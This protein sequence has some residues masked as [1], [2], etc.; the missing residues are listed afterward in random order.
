MP[1]VPEIEETLTI[2]R[3]TSTPSSRSRLAGSRMCGAAARMIRNG[4]I[5]W[6]SSILWNAS[7][8]IVWTTPSIV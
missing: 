3:K 6:M 5:V 4:T 1:I 2:L 7:S 8:V